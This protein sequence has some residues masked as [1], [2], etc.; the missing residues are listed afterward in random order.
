MTV[1]ENIFQML[2]YAE[3]V[4]HLKKYIPLNTLIRKAFL[5]LNVNYNKCKNISEI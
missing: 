2:Q 1:I 5:N 3:K 4:L